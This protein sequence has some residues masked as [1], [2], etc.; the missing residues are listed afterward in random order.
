MPLLREF[1]VFLR[2]P[3]AHTLVVISWVEVFADGM[4]VEA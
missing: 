3:L 1:L 4:Y 2:C